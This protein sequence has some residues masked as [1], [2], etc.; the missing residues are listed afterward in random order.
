MKKLDLNE[1]AREFEMISH[2]LHLFYN[3]QT[4]EFGFYG[5]FMD[6]E[7]AN[8]E[9]FESDEWVAAPSQYDIGEYDIME[10]FAESVTNTRAN[11]LLMVALEGKG[12]FR[13]FKDTLH[14]VGLNEEWF[15][16]KH[17]AFVKIA[18]EWCIDNEIDYIEI[19][20]EEMPANKFE[21]NRGCENV[22]E[23]PCP[24]SECPNHSKCCSCVA[25]HREAGNLPFCLREI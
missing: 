16:F 1:A 21:G 6:E 22:P 24:K 14:R 3:T 23:C 13:R 20:D 10:E 5:D 17:K 15:A 2:D 11:E 19:I 7:T 4:G 25:K 8:S 12:A 9:E 18:R